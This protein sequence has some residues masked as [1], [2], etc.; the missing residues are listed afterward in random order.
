M[1]AAG[2]A[3]TTKLKFDQLAFDSPVT[4]A[5]RSG[6][7]YYNFAFTDNDGKV[8]KCELPAGMAEGDYTPDEW[9][10]TFCLYKLPEVVKQK[11]EKKDKVGLTDF[12]FIAPRQDA[13]ANSESDPSA[14]PPATDSQ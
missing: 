12:P 14:M 1:P 11:T 2:P 7:K 5:D 9:V 3:I 13:P 4:K 10:R 8:Y 6:V